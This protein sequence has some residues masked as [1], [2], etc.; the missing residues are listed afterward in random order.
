MWPPLVAAVVTIVPWPPGEYVP[1]AYHPTRP[2]GAIF[3]D[4]IGENIVGIDTT[5]A[6]VLEVFG[7]PLV[8][9]WPCVYYRQV[10]DPGRHWRFCF[11]EQRRME[12]AMGNVTVPGAP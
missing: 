5:Y 1:S 11:D 6:R 9:R 7:P 10:G 3:N 8:R 12:S 2:V 4:E